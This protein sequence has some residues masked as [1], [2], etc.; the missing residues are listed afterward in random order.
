MNKRMVSIKG[1]EKAAVLAALYN[2]ATTENA[3]LL[4]YDPASMTV[5]QARKILCSF[6][7]VTKKILF[8]EIEVKPADKYIY[9]DY[10][11][12]RSMKVDLSNN[13]E[14]D[15]GQYDLYNREGAN[16]EGAEDAIKS[17]REIGDVNPL[18]TQTAHRAG[19]LIAL[20]ENDGPSN[21]HKEEKIRSLKER[22]LA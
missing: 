20:E 1:L 15:A 18:A 12:G 6:E 10:L 7:R 16:R 21:I 11:K 14:F 19:L 8:W 22:L 5:E 2:R 17:L 4:Q 3:R 13:E 9:F